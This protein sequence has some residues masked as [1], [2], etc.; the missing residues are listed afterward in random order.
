MRCSRGTSW[1]GRRSRRRSTGKVILTS[2]S[3]FLTRKVRESIKKKE[4]QIEK[5]V[6]VDVGIGDIER[7]KGA[8]TRNGGVGCA[9]M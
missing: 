6:I 7:Q 8:K 5:Q 3:P 2:S 9:T 1:R 4:Q